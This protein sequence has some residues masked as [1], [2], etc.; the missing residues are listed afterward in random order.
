MAAGPPP[1]PDKADLSPAPPSD[2]AVC[3]ETAAAPA[4]PTKRRWR[5]RQSVRQIRNRAN[6]R[7]PF[8]ESAQRDNEETRLPTDEAVHLGGLTIVEA[9][10]PSTISAL[11]RALEEL[12]VGDP[13]KTEGWLADLKSSRSAARGQGWQ[14]LGV[15]RPPGEF[16]HREGFNDETLPD[17]VAAV[18]INMHY[19]TPSVA[20]VVATFTL[21]EAAGELSDILRRDYQTEL[22]GTYLHI[23]GR[24]GNLRLRI[25]WARPSS[26]RVM[27][28][29]HDVGHQK[30]QAY[31][32][33]AT[34]YEQECWGW[35]TRW[36]RGRFSAE[37]V[38]NRPCVRLLFTKEQVPFS[39]KSR[40]LE[41]V[42][43]SRVPPIVWRSPED[44]GWAIRLDDR[45]VRDHRRFAAVAAARRADAAKPDGPDDGQSLWHLT[46]TFHD[47]QS[48]LFVRW[49]T[50][51]LLSLY[52]D[53]LGELR[54]RAGAP[55]LLGLGR[56]VR[57]AR[58]LNSFLL[59]DGLDASTVAS[60]LHKFAKEPRAF[61]WTVMGYTEDRTE[62]PES[63]S[64]GEPLNLTAVLRAAVQ[65]QTKR[66]LDDMATTTG[67]LRGS[68]ELRQA[69]TNTRLQRAVIALSI[70]AV[71]IAVVSLVVSAGGT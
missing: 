48:P 4:K 35:F 23:P 9:F 11:Y 28:D 34:K 69:M 14:N 15:V 12:P 29:I 63:R 22:C 26:Y 45:G 3:D 31:D 65:S 56:P 13:K 54:D 68:A 32:A 1:A 7:Q 51:C 6:A 67:N 61:G 64:N 42:G 27:S 57:Q 39:G 16:V 10:T 60:D 21:G 44:R 24:F 43:L 59:G 52:A 5:D 38:S 47:Y 70:L 19:E 71:I 62:Y 41:T 30:H 20:M 18:W 2:D 49:A 50:T 36:F 8:A 17:G 58:D 33:L 37:E 46:Q 66:L 40:A 25:P 53:R 55:K